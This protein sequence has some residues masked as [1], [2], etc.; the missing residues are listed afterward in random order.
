MI[1]KREN[2]RSLDLEIQQR[3]DDPEWDERILAGTLR[4]LKRE[5]MRNR[6]AV[7]AGLFVLMGGIIAGLYLQKTTLPGSHFSTGPGS[8]EV[9][10]SDDLTDMRFAER[11]AFPFREDREVSILLGRYSVGE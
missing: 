4:S 10:P 3:L 2:G 5:R 9:L 11:E 8:S 1:E 6:L 7:A